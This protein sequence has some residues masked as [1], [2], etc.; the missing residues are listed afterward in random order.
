MIENDFTTVNRLKIALGEFGGPDVTL[1]AG[2][3]LD[4]IPETHQYLISNSMRQAFADPKSFLKSS[5]ALP[6]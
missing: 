4:A 2:G 3:S 1:I 5:S 6:F